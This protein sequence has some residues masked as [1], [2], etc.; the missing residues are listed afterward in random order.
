V[1]LKEQI[2]IKRFMVMGSSE[3]LFS[4]TI[5]TRKRCFP[6]TGYYRSGKLY[7]SEEINRTILE[8]PNEMISLGNATLE[9]FNGVNTVRDPITYFE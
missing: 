8:N 7:H 3:Q 1:F 2:S 4:L 6:E 9:R 5:W